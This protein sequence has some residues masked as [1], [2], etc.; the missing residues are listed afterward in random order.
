LKARAY[1]ELDRWSLR[2]ARRVLTVSEPFRDE[3][4]SRGVKRER[5]EI[6]HN[7]IPTNWG[8]RDGKESE[9]QLLRQKFAIPSDRRVILIVG[10][11]S[12]EKDHLTLL[13]A[14]ARLIRL[15]GSGAVPHLLV[16]GE[17]P[18]RPVIEARIRSL[19]LGN[20]VTLTGQQKSAEPFYRIS[21]LAVLSSLSEGS[22]NALLEALAAGVPTVATAVGGIPEI[23]TNSDAAILIRPRAAE[24]MAAAMGRILYD[25]PSLAK[26]MA[27]RGKAL[28]AEKHTPEKRAQH[29]IAIYRGVLASR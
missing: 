29:L 22:P 7:A 13:D 3:L 17:G 8:A 23:I 16:V 21:D 10:R 4:A 12:R 5:M 1:N 19:D 24:E 6:I 20:Y 15:A 14:L 26:A 27:E 11:L 25:D 18:E 28:V 9:S 2:E